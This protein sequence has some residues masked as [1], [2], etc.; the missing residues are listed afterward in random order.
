M[1]F[2]AMG[3]ALAQGRAQRLEIDTQR[4][5][6]EFNITNDKNN[7]ALLAQQTGAREEQS[8][9]EA[10]QL[11]GAQRAAIAQS[12]VGFGG[13]SADIIRQ[14]TMNSELDAL[15]IRY[16]GDLERMGILN[17]I[18][19]RKYSV[20]LLKKK[21]E[22]VMRMRVGTALSALF[23]GQGGAQPGAT[24]SARQSS[25]AM[26]KDLSKTT[27]TWAASKTGAYGGYGRFGTGG[28]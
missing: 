12:G 9:R 15:N 1:N 16:A 18:E 24:A 28:D 22:Q 2:F 25:G 6:E 10:R 27:H 4:A 5:I 14:S 8:R 11:L 26:Q 17:E 20:Q 23:G 7:A 13:S 3:D 19:M 21:G